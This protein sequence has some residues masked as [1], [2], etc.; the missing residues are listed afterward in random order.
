M[1][2]AARDAVI[3]FYEL[4][5]DAGGEIVEAD[6]NFVAKDEFDKVYLSE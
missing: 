1:L 6:F 2:T 4:E 3:V 5:Y